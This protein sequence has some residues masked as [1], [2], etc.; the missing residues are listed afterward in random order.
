MAVNVSK[1]VIP[2]ATLPGT[3]AGGMKI[4]SQARILKKII[5]WL[6]VIQYYLTTNTAEGR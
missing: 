4:E 2:I 5:T 3:D 1:V 6:N